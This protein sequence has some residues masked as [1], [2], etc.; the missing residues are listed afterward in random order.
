MVE[1]NRRRS[2]KGDSKLRCANRTP[3]FGKCRTFPCSCCV[4]DDDDMY[5]G[6]KEFTVRVI[7]NNDMTLVTK[8]VLCV[9]NFSFFRI[10]AS[11]C[12]GKVFIIATIFATNS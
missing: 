9:R 7:R 1:F 10:V 3:H 2:F 5:V 6:V 4:V 11:G 8:C 12:C